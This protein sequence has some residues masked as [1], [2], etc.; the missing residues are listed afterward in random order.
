MLLS[1]MLLFLLV[2]CFESGS[3]NHP[4][5]RLLTNPPAVAAAS[6]YGDQRTTRPVLPFA[7]SSTFWSAYRPLNIPLPLSFLRRAGGC[8]EQRSVTGVGSGSQGLACRR[9]AA[10]AALKEKTRQ[11]KKKKKCFLVSSLAKPASRHG[12]HGWRRRAGAGKCRFDLQML[13]WVCASR[14]ILSAL[15]HCYSVTNS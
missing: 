6:G 15:H 8:G 4:A 10:V 2:D 7:A 5:V 11:K 1:L 13:L 12:R 3:A 14:L 9:A